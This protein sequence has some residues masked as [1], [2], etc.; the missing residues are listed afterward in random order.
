MRRKLPLTGAVRWGTCSCSDLLLVPLL[1]EPLRHR[2]VQPTQPAS[3]TRS[4]V[5]Q[6]P[7]TPPRVKAGTSRP[8]RTEA[9]LALAVDSLAEPFPVVPFFIL[10]R[11]L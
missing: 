8:V 11:F 6:G 10:T 3:P 2:K 4:R 1:A 9:V 5:Q 7:L